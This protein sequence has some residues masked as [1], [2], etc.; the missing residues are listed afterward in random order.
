MCA[1]PIVAV[2]RDVPS[3]TKLIPTVAIKIPKLGVNRLCTMLKEPAKI[4]IIP[5]MPI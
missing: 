2:V 3:A 1:W 4:A 5:R